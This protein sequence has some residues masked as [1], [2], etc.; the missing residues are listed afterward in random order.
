MVGWAGLGLVGG[1]VGGVK[2]RLSHIDTAEERR[3]RWVN[4]DSTHQRDVEMTGYGCKDLLEQHP[5]REMKGQV[6]RES[7][8]S[9]SVM[10][11]KSALAMALDA[12]SPNT[13][14]LG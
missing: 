11:V 2:L 7:R 4:Y 8:E 14:R 10:A 9:T 13:H 12:Y 1:W 6:K 5:L 3:T